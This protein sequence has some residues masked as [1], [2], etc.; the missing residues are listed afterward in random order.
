MVG[1]LDDLPARV[2]IIWSMRTRHIH[3]KLH[4]KIRICPLPIGRLICQLAVLFAHSSGEL[5]S[6]ALFSPRGPLTDLLGTLC[7]MGKEPLQ[8]IIFMLYARM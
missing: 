6:P 2:K 1:R 8:N 5:K 4:V 7:H 3:G